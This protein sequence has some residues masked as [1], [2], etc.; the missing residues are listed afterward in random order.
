MQTKRQ[1]I[2]FKCPTC[3]H[4]APYA[5][6]V[7]EGELRKA[8]LCERC[9]AV[10]KARNYLGRMLVYGIGMGAVAAAI[11]Y[12]VWWAT[13]GVIDSLLA[14][15]VA[16]IIICALAWV[17]AYP[18]SRFLTWWSPIDTNPGRTPNRS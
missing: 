7:Q 8:Y 6:R 5:L 13:R 12:G 4:E 14:L 15:L 18:F 10:S 1:R 16:L 9:G 17:V 2:F 11:T 3:G